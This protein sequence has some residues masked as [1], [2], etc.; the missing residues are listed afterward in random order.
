MSMGKKITWKVERRRLADLKSWDKNPRKAT[1]HGDEELAD[2]IKRFGLPE[3]PV[4]QPDGGL[5]AGHRRVKVMIESGETETDCMVSSRKLTDRERSELAIRLNHHA[6][7][8]DFD[9]LAN[10]ELEDLSKWGFKKG[11]ISKI[12]LSTLA[13]EIAGAKEWTPTHDAT[14]KRIEKVQEKIKSIKEKHPEAIAKGK[15]IILSADH[16]ETLI[17]VDDS[18]KD[19]IA[20]IRRYVDQGID[21]PLA[22]LINRTHKI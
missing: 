15:A 19:V 6:G 10:F 17:I 8:W 7:E 14:D 21:S 22:E 13:E 1:E 2:G 12:N 20:E 3:L 4:I 9:L 16:N 5:I 18:L 11:D